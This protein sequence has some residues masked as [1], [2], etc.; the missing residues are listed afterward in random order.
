MAAC[1]LSCAPVANVG[2]TKSILKEALPVIKKLLLVIPVVG[3][4]ALATAPRASADSFALNVDFCSNPCLGGAVSGGTVTLTLVNVGTST[5]VQFDIL[6]NSPLDFHQTSG[7]DAF[8]F[9]DSGSQALTY[10]SVTSGFTGQPLGTYHEDGA[11]TFDYIVTY[12]TSPGVDGTHLSFIVS[13]AGALTLAEFETLSSGGSPSV[14]FAA[15]VTNGVCTG[16]IGGGNG[17]GQSTAHVVNP[18]GTCT[19]PPPPPPPVPEPA[20]LALLGSG[21]ALLGARMRRKKA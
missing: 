15:N 10:S 18:G 5:D 21:L 11:G 8:M 7:L 4:F 17:T 6:L 9:N 14:D 2:G 20:S 19:A 1:L 16:L 13:A 3:F 12:N